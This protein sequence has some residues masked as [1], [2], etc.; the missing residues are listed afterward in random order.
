VGF[1][2]FTALCKQ[3]AARRQLANVSSIT[4]TVLPPKTSAGLHVAPTKQLV[5]FLTGV[6]H[7]HLPNGTDEAYILGGAPG[8]ILVAVDTVGTGHYSENPSNVPVTA[9]QV[10]FVHGIPPPYE[11]LAKG[12]C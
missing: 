5:V 7:I 6:S 8:S 11:V 1:D 4:Y 2:Y 10:P 3:S 9:L 12:A